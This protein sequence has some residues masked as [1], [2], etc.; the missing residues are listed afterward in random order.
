MFEADKFRVR[1]AQAHVQDSKAEGKVERDRE[2]TWM[3][4][5][6]PREKS[7]HTILGQKGASG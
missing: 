7:K 1:L 5:R 3:T 6:G 4:M 2:W